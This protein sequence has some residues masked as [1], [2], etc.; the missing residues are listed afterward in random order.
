M[1]FGCKGNTIRWE[2]K[3]KL[4]ENVSFRHLKVLYKP[5]KQ[6]RADLRQLSC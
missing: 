4:L 2:Y 3:K 5:V 1:K 6:V